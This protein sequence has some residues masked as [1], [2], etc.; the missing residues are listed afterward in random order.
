MQPEQPRHWLC[1]KSW[2][3]AIFPP[4]CAPN[5]PRGD[6]PRH[7]EVCGKSRIGRSLPCG[8][9]FVVMTRASQPGG[10]FHDHLRSS[11]GNS[12]S[13]VAGAPFVST[14]SDCHRSFHAEKDDQLCLALCERC[15]DA[16]AYPHEPIISVHARP[17]PLFPSSFW[18]RPRSASRFA[19][20]TSQPC[21]T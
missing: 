2:L 19:A 1:L 6:C 9:S 7:S 10:S 5:G 17:R 12:C 13:R 15:L 21:V 16:A 14:C 20:Q 4:Q 8:N 11:S 18:L 3:A